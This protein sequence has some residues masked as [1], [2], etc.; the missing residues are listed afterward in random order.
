MDAPETILHPTSREL[1][2]YWERLRKEDSAPQKNTLELKEIPSLLPHIGIL[3]RHPLKQQYSWR[4]AGTGLCKL[5]GR[6]MTGTQFLK[7]WPEFEASVVARMLDAVVSSHQPAIA[8]IRASNS[9]GEQ[10][11]LEL[12]ALPLATE[13]PNRTLVLTGLMAFRQPL[14]L[15]KK[16][17]TQFEL[18]RVKMI[19]TEHAGTNACD[20]HLAAFG[21]GTESEP[22]RP[23]FRVIEGGRAD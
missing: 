13:R 16:Q 7:G 12:L 21:D 18:S 4:L 6:E 22:G 5:F 8:R 1:F 23:L 11:G 14:W 15:G 9:V 3:E 20:S 17:L 2:R 10:L 19:T